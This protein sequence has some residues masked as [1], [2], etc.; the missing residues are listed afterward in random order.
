MGAPKGVARKGRVSKEAWGIRAGRR[1][2]GRGEKGF[3]CF[4]LGLFVRSFV[5]LFVLKKETPA[6]DGV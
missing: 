2:G 5:C 6:R 3:V 1:R 4:F